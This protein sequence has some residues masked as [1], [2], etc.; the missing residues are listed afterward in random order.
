MIVP[1][2][3]YQEIRKELIADFP[4]AY[5]K[6]EYVLQD[7]EKMMRKQKLKTHLHVYDYV[8]RNKNKW[9]IH[10]DVGKKDVARFFMTYFYVENKIAAVGVIDGKQLLYFTTHFFKRYKERLKLDIA[11]PEDILRHY[12]K[13][14]SHYV[15]DYLGLVN[16]NVVKVF[17]SAKQGVILGNLHRDIGFCKMNTFITHDMLKEDQ[18]ERKSQMKEMLNKY[19]VDS[20]RLD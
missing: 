9:I 19:Y 20:G 15:V 6:S 2:M 13:H 5:K 1:S 18:V 8:S 14:S 17:I 12:V 10:I 16:E 7:I 11:V 4:I 3:T